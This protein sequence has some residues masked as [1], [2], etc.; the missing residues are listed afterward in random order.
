M[1][2]IRV[3]VFFV[4]IQSVFAMHEK[5]NVS[6]EKKSKIIVNEQNNENSKKSG[7]SGITPT[8]AVNNKNV[9][10]EDQGGIRLRKPVVK[11]IVNK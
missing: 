2:K 3:L 6:G 7:N 5:E 8:G 11:T 9:S 1:L 10:Q 4:V